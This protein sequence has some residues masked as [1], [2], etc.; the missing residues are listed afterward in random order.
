MRPYS[1]LVMRGA[2]IVQLRKVTKDQLEG[3]IEEVDTGKQAKFLSDIE[4]IAFVRERST[5]AQQRAQQ[6]E[7]PNEP[8][9]GGR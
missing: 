8:N 3:V 6:E 4:L 9:D 7:G 1:E 2:F 5:H